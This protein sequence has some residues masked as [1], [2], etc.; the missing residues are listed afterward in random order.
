MPSKAKHF[1]N[2]PDCN[3][4]TSGRYCDKH[5]AE[6]ERQ[7]RESFKQYDKRRG[8]ANERGYNFRWQQYSKA[9][10]RRPENQICKLHLPGCT[11]MAECV[12]HVVPMRGPDD[13]RFWDRSNHQAA[14]IHCNSVK[15]HKAMVGEYDMM[16]DIEGME[17]STYG[18]SQ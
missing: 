18:H 7:Q 8:T 1:C 13:P 11:I 4:L 12:D 3:E 10:L 16:D 14:C 5:K 9:F 15:G 17:E 2:F 6:Y